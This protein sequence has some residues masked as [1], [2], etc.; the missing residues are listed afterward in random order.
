M[1]KIAAK[2]YEE[3]WILR[4]GAA[5]GADTAFEVGALTQKRIYYANDAT[6]ESMAVAEIFHPAWHKCS[7][8][9]KKLHGRNLFQV[10][11]RDLKTPVSFVI[12]WTPDGAQTHQERVFATGGTGTA[13]SIASNHNIPVFNLKNEYQLERIQRWL[14]GK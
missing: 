10:L 11:G 14:K 5:L 2:L 3:G 6:K 9:A 4:S 12:C 13:I 8:Y 7:E 1:T